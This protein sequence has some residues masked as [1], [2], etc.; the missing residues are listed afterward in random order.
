MQVLMKRSPTL[1]NIRGRRP[2]LDLFAHREGARRNVSTKM[3]RNF[4]AGE[5]AV[6][7]MP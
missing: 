2:P 7:R 6:E 3:T 4:R 5:A 1:A